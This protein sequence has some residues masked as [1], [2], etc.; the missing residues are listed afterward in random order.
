MINI[1]LD[2]IINDY[3]HILTILLI[4]YQYIYQYFV[5]P[6]IIIRVLF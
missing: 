6:L 4:N 1:E 2:T 3:N 5:N